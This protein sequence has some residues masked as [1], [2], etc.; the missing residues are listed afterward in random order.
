[1]DGAIALKEVRMSSDPR[2][3]TALFRYRIVAEATN[4]RLTPAERG[5][6]VRELASRAYEHP[7]RSRWTYSRGTLDRWLRACR[8]HGLDGLLP[9]P[10]SDLGVVRRHPQLLDKPASCAESCRA[11]RP[12]RSARS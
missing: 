5:Q 4:P 12:P 9:P 7:D 1:L 11:A 10:R 2:E 6:L 8:D 3:T